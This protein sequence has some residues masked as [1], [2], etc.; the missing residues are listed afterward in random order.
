MQVAVA[1]E[2][3][4]RHLGERA[5]GQVGHHDVQPLAAL[6]SGDQVWRRN[7]KAAVY[8]RERR[9]LRVEMGPLGG[10]NPNATAAQGPRRRSEGATKQ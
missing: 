3:H 8:A 5:S 4:V 2:K 1:M 9:R 10:G 7:R 6:T